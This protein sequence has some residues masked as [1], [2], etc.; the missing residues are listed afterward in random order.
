MCCMCVLLYYSLP[1]L[2]CPWP[3]PL[4]NGQGVLVISYSWLVW[5]WDSCPVVVSWFWQRNSVICPIFRR[6]GL[7]VWKFKTGSSNWGS[8]VLPRGAYLGMLGHSLYAGSSSLELTMTGK[9]MFFG[10][11]I[12]SQ[13]MHKNNKRHWLDAMQSWPR[14]SLNPLLSCKWVTVKEVLYIRGM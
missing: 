3:R 4:V 1:K 11:A 8:D 7:K 10:Y 6:K 9:S 5:A 12:R 14:F 13:W 2:E